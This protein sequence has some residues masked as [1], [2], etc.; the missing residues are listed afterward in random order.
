MDTPDYLKANGVD[1]T[2]D[3]VVDDLP[4]W[5]RTKHGPLI[6]VPYSL[7]LNDGPIWAG[8]GMDSDEQYRRT[9]STLETF[10]D[11]LKTNCRVLVLPLHPHLV[12][13]PH[14]ILVARKD[15]IFVTPSQIADW[16]AKVEPA[17][18]D[19]KV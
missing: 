1:Y 17:P 4:S 15:T 12:G 6:A 2:C 7:D 10:E 9:V 19:M 11:E 14:D 13:V 3:W 8:W 5:M 16:Y 18:A